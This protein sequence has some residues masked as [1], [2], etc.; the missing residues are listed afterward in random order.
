MSVKIS[1]RLLVLVI[2]TTILVITAALCLTLTWRQSNSIVSSTREKSDA[3]FNVLYD[4]AL[5]TASD[6]NERWVLST[7]A[8]ILT[9]LSSST[10]VIP[11]TLKVTR[12]VIERYNTD[13]SLLSLLPTLSALLS[14]SDLSQIYYMERTSGRTIGVLHPSYR[15]F[16][17][18][19]GYPEYVQNMQFLLYS[20]GTTRRE[21]GIV[22]KNPDALY[23][24]LCA[25]GADYRCNNTVDL[26]VP[27]DTGASNLSYSEDISG[28]PWV[29]NWDT[30]SPFY[31]KGAQAFSSEDN[32]Y[33][34][35]LSPI[36]SYLTA[37]ANVLFYD[38]TN[39]SNAFALAFTIRD[40]RQVS[41]QLKRL[42]V[43]NGQRIYMVTTRSTIIS[44][45]SL[46]GASHGD[47]N[48]YSIVN[49]TYTM[50]PSLSP[51]P[52]VATESDDRLIREV[53]NALL[54]THGL[55][56]NVPLGKILS[57]R[58]DGLAAL[59][60]GSDHFV[61]AFSIDDEATL[62]DGLIT[63][64]VIPRELTL[65]PT[66]AQYDHVLHRWEES[67]T[68]LD[69]ENRKLFIRTTLILLGFF[70]SCFVGVVLYA[71]ATNRSAP[72][73]KRRNGC[74]CGD[75]LRHISTDAS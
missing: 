41:A 56:M 16:N 30:E 51:I 70:Y 6:V 3:S 36:D 42:V 32:V 29:L 24:T 61:Y 25:L 22:D 67:K 65:G 55:W 58:V 4:A 13:D 19:S 26:S 47:I 64:V 49:S 10:E 50:R 23:A 39:K 5:S 60:F 9:D 2:S 62:L 14:S 21:H 31:Y 1:F 38:P 68:E 28:F 17:N 46:V 20:D 44:H 37:A 8:S 35:P 53:S 43:G 11:R 18:M 27:I 12:R 54:R 69:D 40:F 48:K 59:E 71:D 75:E 74:R 33:W 72:S 45:G 73:S 7:A 34:A 66:D 63:I 52:I 15:S 57:V